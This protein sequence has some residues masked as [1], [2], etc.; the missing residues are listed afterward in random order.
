MYV[1]EMNKEVEGR[2]EIASI[3]HFVVINVTQS[4]AAIIEGTYLQYWR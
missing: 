3:G 1:R 4:P 2:M